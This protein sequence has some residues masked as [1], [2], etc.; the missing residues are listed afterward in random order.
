MTPHGVSALS[1]ERALA[2]SDEVANRAQVLAQTSLWFQFETALPFSL[3][4]WA[5]QAE[6]RRLDW[7]ST[8]GNYRSKFRT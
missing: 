2:Q 1:V 8:W 7:H 6:H 4:P 5:R 3:S